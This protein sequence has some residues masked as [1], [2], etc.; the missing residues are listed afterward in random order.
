MFIQK[1]VRPVFSKKL[2]IKREILLHFWIVWP[3][4]RPILTD[5]NYKMCRLDLVSY[6]GT[7]HPETHLCLYSREETTNEQLVASKS[8]RMYVIETRKGIFDAQTPTGNN[9]GRYANQ[10]GVLEALKRVQEMSAINKP[11]MSEHDWVTIEKELDDK[12]NAKFKVVTGQLVLVAKTTIPHSRRPTEI[13]TNYGSL[14]TYWISAERE[15]PG[16]FGGQISRIVDFLLNSD[17]CNWPA[18]KR[19]LWSCA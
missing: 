13:Y 14:R 3:A 7:I 17:D 8:S 2:E 15:N 18:E 10:L 9:L 5:F 4:Q 11:P 6:A 12:A 19:R 16:C 1:R